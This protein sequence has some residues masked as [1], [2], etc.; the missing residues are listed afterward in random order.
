MRGANKMNGTFTKLDKS[1]T[2]TLINARNDT[3][4]EIVLP[5]GSIVHAAERIAKCISFRASSDGSHFEWM[6]AQVD[7]FLNA[8]PLAVVEEDSHLTTLSKSIES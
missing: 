7:A 8:V 3:N 1:L 6:H 5:P 2:A 4:P